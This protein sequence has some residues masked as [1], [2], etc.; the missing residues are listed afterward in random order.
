MLR[1]SL[2]QLGK[3][4]IICIT[5]VIHRTWPCAGPVATPNGMILQAHASKFPENS[6]C[7]LPLVLRVLSLGLNMHRPWFG[8]E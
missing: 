5:R 2:L 7:S 8:V 6:C 4:S 3:L 1:G